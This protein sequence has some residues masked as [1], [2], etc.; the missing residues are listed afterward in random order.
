MWFLKW[1]PFA[2]S[3]GHNPLLTN[4]VDYPAGA[5]LMWNGS[6]PLVDFLLAPLTTTLGA[7]FA[8]NVMA[9]LAVALSAWSAFLLIRRYVGRPLAAAIGGLLYGFSP[10]MMA[11]L[12]G[13]PALFIVFLPPLIFLLIDD[14]LIRQERRPLATGILLGLLGGAQ[15]LI[16]QEVLL[17][18]ALVAVIAIV[19]LVE[20]DRPRRDTARHRAGDPLHGPDDP[21]RRPREPYP[22]LRAG[23]R[24]ST[25]GAL[26]PCARDA[27]RR[28]PAVV[29]TDQGAAPRQHPPGPDDVVR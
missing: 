17:L 3:H 13:H 19:L 7:V 24:L 28:D 27:L 11:H 26:P 9:T 4:Y 29:G 5:N 12:L 10:Y 14:A 2:I 1:L 23:P 25:A 18:T 22:C 21:L 20:P 16:G 6:M 8:Y 15:F